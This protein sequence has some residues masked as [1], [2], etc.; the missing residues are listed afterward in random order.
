MDPDTFLATL[1]QHAGWVEIAK[2]VYVGAVSGE[3]VPDIGGPNKGMPVGIRY[4][5]Q[6]V[7]ADAD[8]TADG[9]GKQFK[10]GDVTVWFHA[11]DYE[12]LDLV[13][14]LINLPPGM[15]VRRG[16]EAVG[17]KDMTIVLSVTV[18]ST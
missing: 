11:E 10:N 14:D 4:M 3:D 2:R 5:Y 17:A 15:P 1:K 12:A 6:H 7:T 13:Y 8:T 9:T 18:T 16:V